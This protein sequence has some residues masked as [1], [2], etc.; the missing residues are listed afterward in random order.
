MD[1]MKKIYMIF[2][3]AALLSAVSCVKDN[4]YDGPL[5]TVEVKQTLVINEVCPQT[6]KLEFYNYGKEEIDLG[7]CY[8]TKDGGDQ[9]NMPSVKLPAGK[10]VVFTAKSADAADGPSFGLSA[11]K[12]FLLELFNSKGE[13]IDKLDNSKDAGNFFSFTES[14]DP[15]EV[16]SLGRKTDGDAQW[17]IF[18]PGSIGE[19][20]ANGKYL[21]DWGAAAPVEEEGGI[22]LNE[23]Y[24]AASADAEKFIELYNTSNKEITITGYTIKKDEALAWT[25][26]EGTKIAAKGFLAII[27]A[28]NSTPDGFSSG[29]SAKKS[30]LV[31]LLDDKE[32]V[33]DTFQRGEQGTGW[34]NT[35]LDAVTGSW[36]RV[37]DGTGKFQIT[38][39]TTPG[40]ANAT[41][42]T[43]DD[44]VIQ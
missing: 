31:Q 27:G 19:S 7:G 20:N 1:I 42:A 8:M 9:W 39:T 14:D 5:P 6:K 34:G 15:S 32:T 40:A 29:F 21:Q 10:V 13:S 18:K 23:L 28:K 43:A 3:A 16:Q 41:D 24:G 44:S 2:A 25:A 12:G 11:T 33:I 30:V 37:P 22:V 35:S 38:E 17:V 26:P 4:V 36:S